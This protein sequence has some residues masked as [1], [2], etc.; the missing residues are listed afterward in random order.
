MLPIAIASAAV[1][2][3][4]LRSSR[5]LKRLDSTTRSP[6]YG[7]FS[8]L[9]TGL[10][11]VRAF[12]SA[13]FFVDEFREAQDTHTR[14]ELY[15]WICNRWLAG[16]LQVLSAFVSVSVGAYSLSGGGGGQLSAGLVLLYA[17]QYVQNIRQCVLQ[18]ASVE[19]SMNYVERCDEYSRLTSQEAASE[20]SPHQL[21]SRDGGGGSG[22]GGGSSGG[23][24]TEG[25]AIA[26]LEERPAWPS[27]G[28]ITIQNLTVQYPSAST[29]ALIDMSLTIPAGT[30]VGVV[31]RT[32]AGKSTLASAL[33]RLVEP[34]DGRVVID[35]VDTS[36]VGLRHLR[37]GIAII[38]QEPTLFEGTLRSNLDPFDERSDATVWSVL[39]TSQLADKV[40]ALPERLHAPVR[41]GGANFSVGERQVT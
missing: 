13:Q 12:G 19:M 18:H 1:G 33:F 34:L 3:F 28:E 38:P 24:A 31:G 23:D 27:Q 7:G 25:G 32:G 15:L 30:R 20:A 14:A 35:G 29:P 10:A 41:E 4:Y 39:R 26:G 21:I 40:A 9:L 8:E 36:L 22:G 5:E 6:I 16:R 37:R 17:C 2:Q 11:T